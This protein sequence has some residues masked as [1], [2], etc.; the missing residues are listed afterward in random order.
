MP[1]FDAWDVVKVP[2]PY[3]NHPVR[4]R[5]P[6][7]VIH[8]RPSEGIPHLLW[9]LMITSAANRG[10]PGD[11]TISDL[12]VAGLPAS[13]IVRTAKVATIEASDA[14][15]IGHLPE[16]D[17]PIVTRHLRSILLTVLG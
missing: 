16:L 10:W 9:V 2:F 7:L 5:R 1:L 17:R 4:Q 6:A 14:E 12:A 3:T 11:V 8:S 15:R 13:S